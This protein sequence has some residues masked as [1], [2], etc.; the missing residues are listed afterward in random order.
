MQASLTFSG[1]I[2]AITVS[3]RGR[4]PKVVTK[5]DQEKLATGIQLTIGSAWALSDVSCQILYTPKTMRPNAD[6]M[7]DIMS[8]I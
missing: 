2:S 4:I 6:P 1:I 3:D 7:H 8:R 5:I